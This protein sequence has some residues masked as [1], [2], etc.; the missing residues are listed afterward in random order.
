MTTTMEAIYANGRL[1]LA[2]PV[3]IPDGT[4]VDVIVIAPGEQ[5]PATEAASVLQRIASLPTEPG[6]EGFSGEDHDLVLYP[7]CGER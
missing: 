5:V 6:T 7:R 4:T 1:Q 2:R 3:D